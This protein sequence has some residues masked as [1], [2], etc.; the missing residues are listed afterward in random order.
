MRAI[1]LM[2]LLV[3]LTYVVRTDSAAGA[4]VWVHVVH[5]VSLRATGGS[6]LWCVYRGL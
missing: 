1:A 2:I 6:A 3:A 5:V 4:A